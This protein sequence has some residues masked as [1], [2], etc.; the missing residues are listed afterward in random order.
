M[1]ALSLQV[2]SFLDPSSYSL[3]IA[4]KFLFLLLIVV[5]SEFAMSMDS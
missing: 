4:G 3:D 5:L 1:L 2:R